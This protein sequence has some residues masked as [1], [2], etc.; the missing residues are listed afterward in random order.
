MAARSIAMENLQQKDL[1]GHNRIEESVAPLGIANRITSRLDGIG[2][3]LGGP[4]GFETL[5]CLG[6]FGNHA[7]GLLGLESALPRG[8]S[9]SF[10]LLSYIYY[11][12]SITEDCD[13]PIL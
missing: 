13:L 3:E 5:E 2:L 12:C 10:A 9:V 8:R 7:G 1:D 4:F 11:Y 6:Q